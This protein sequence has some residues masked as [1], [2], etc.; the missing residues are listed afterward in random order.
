M[1]RV[2]DPGEWNLAE[3]GDSRQREWARTIGTAC[4]D[5]EGFWQRHV[6]PLTFRPHQPENYFIRPTQKKPLLDMADGSY[7]MFLHLTGALQW[8][9]W[10]LER[11]EEPML[12]P[13]D[14]VFYFFSHTYSLLEA[15]AWFALAVD[16]T[17][18]EYHAEPCFRVYRDEE[19]RHFQW[20]SSPR[21][22]CWRGLQTLSNP[23]RNALIHQRPL[24]V[25]GNLLPTKEGIDKLS[26][27]TAIS[28]LALRDKSVWD[29]AVPANE[30]I[31]AIVDSASGLCNE[32]W[33]WSARSLDGLAGSKYTH[34]QLR[35]R[36][37]DGQL[38]LRK[39]HAARGA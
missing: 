6:L 39:I 11:H 1:A 2:F 34:D 8:S 27:L 33:R 4:P 29:H 12:R 28:K 35:L 19:A 17:L 16:Q 3:H 9:G 24:F 37:Q 22:T 13:T 5:Y 20:E 15:S 31:H 10:L 32:F 23:Y 18:R 21:R 26:G 36:P 7:A 30:V 14:C 25:Q 38:T